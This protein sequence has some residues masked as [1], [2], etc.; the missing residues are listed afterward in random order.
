MRAGSAIVAN[1]IAAFATGNDDPFA[2]VE[3]RAR[4]TPIRASRLTLHMTRLGLSRG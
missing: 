3:S 1:V 2:D 4:Y